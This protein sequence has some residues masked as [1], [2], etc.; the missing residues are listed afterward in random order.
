M[1]SFLRHGTVLSRIAY[2]A[3]CLALLPIPFTWF[4][5]AQA[6]E[7]S[8]AYPSKP[9]RIIV[10]FPPG[11]AADILARLLAERLGDVYKQPFVVE[12]RSGA[13]GTIGAGQVAR[14]PG[15]G[16]TL[17]LGVTAS[18]TIAPSIYKDLAYDPIKDFEPVAMLATIP[19]ALVVTASVAATTVDDLVILAKKADPPLAFASSGVG[20]IP[21]L[22]GALFRQS[23]HINLLHVPFKGSSPALT[24]LLGGRVH[25]MFDHLPS[26]LPFIKSGKLRALAIAGDKRAEALPDVPTLGEAGIGGVAV[27]SW[28]GLLA[29]ANTPREIVDKLNKSVNEQ[30][31]RT[32]VRESITA[33]GAEVSTTTPQEFAEIVR[34][35]SKQWADVVQSTGTTTN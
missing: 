14:A 26:S 9:V 30:L 34:V 32:D 8:A 22:T 3:V 5:E 4:A 12:N 35:D 17:L 24:E 33:F 15:D 19:V 1:R 28:F 7:A 16:Y 13:G 18:Q 6:A 10:G 21:H 25:I 27:R 11:G 2:A 31:A 23:Q 29:P 20:A